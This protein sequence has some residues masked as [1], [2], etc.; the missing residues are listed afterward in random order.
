MRDILFVFLVFS[1]TSASLA[2]DPEVIAETEQYWI[3]SDQSIRFKPDDEAPD[4]LSEAEARAL[5]TQA[6]MAGRADSGAETRAEHALAGEWQGFGGVPYGCNGTISV[7]KKGPDDKIYLAGSFS[8]CNDVIVNNITAWD[9]DTNTFEALGAGFTVTVN[10]IAFTPAGD[11]IAVASNSVWRWDNLTWARVGADY[12]FNSTIR[13]VAVD[14]DA[15]EEIIYVG[16]FFTGIFRSGEGSFVVNRIARWDGSTETW[17]GL[18]EGFNNTVETLAVVNGTLFAG[19]RFTESGTQALGRVAEWDGAQWLDMGGGTDNTVLALASDGARLFAG[20]SLSNAG[21]VETGPIALWDG[22]AWSSIEFPT[23]C[24]RDIA[25]ADGKLF[26]TGGF[27]DLGGVFTRVAIWDEES[28]S[29]PAADSRMDGLGEVV[30]FDGSDLY[31]GGSFSVIGTF[32][33]QNFPAEGSFAN[34]VA[35]LAA[36]SEEWQ[37][38]GNGEGNNLNGPV[39]GL[40]QYQGELWVTGNFTAA[41]TRPMPGRLARWTGSQWQPPAGD[42]PPCGSFTA[43]AVGT[44]DDLFA[45]TSCLGSGGVTWRRTARFDGTSWQP[46]GQGLNGGP[47]GIAVDPS[48]GDAYFVGSFTETGDEDPITVNRIARWDGVNWSSVGDGAENGVSSTTLSSPSITAVAA[49]DG[50]L[51]V[52][53]FFDRAGTVE[54]DRIALWDGSAWSVP[55]DGLTYRDDLPFIEDLAAQGSSVF[56][57]GFIDQSGD[58]ALRNIARWDGSSWQPLAGADGEGIAFTPRVLHATAEALYVGGSFLEAGGRLAQRIVQWDGSDWRSL[59]SG[60][61]NGLARAGAA[62]SP[63]SAILATSRGVFVGGTFGGS[64]SVAS[65]NFI[66]FGDPVDPD[67]VFQS[68]FEPFLGPD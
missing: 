52:A 63:V 65:P 38:L 12:F 59:G 13:S 17:S 36:D 4:L 67:I 10:D 20:G 60:A 66:L 25:Y 50:G 18:G 61:E 6:V 34:R 9:P 29:A 44:N 31:V 40:V 23:C 24:V 57:A 35:R 68:R 47:S 5:S 7:I 28:W 53:G 16:G 21:G 11:L 46:L 54:V 39:S 2:S 1:L 55:G 3:Y 48:T 33:L 51:M 41:G 19:G 30:F 37:A 45:G 22:E 56:A 14:A 64:E 43:L 49:F 27:V 26:V 58:Q 8:A 15:E 62:S 32:F 42:N